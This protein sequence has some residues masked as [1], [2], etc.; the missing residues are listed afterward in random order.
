MSTIAIFVYMYTNVIVLRNKTASREWE[1]D[2]YSKMVMVMVAVVMVAVVMVM[3]MVANT[4]SRLTLLNVV[5][6]T[7][8]MAIINHILLGNALK[9]MQS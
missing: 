6:L 2:I 3:V 1:N 9:D 4:P 8:L 7:Q 5:S